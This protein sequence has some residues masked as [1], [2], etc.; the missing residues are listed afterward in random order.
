MFLKRG[1]ILDLSKTKKSVS[2]KS[3]FVKKQIHTCRFLEAI[4]EIFSRS[5]PSFSLI[6][7]LPTFAFTRVCIGLEFTMFH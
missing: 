6:K 4:T 2:R 5:L 1:K 7:L 3:F